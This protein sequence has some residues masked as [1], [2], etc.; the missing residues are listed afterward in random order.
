MNNISP[1]IEHTKQN[2]LVYYRQ[3]EIGGLEQCVF[4]FKDDVYQALTAWELSQKNFE[5]LIIDVTT[6]RTHID[7][8]RQANDEISAYSELSYQ[9]FAIN[10]LIAQNTTDP[11]LKAELQLTY[12]TENYKCLN[13]ENIRDMVDT[14][15][16]WILRINRSWEKYEEFIR[17]FLE[18]LKTSNSVDSLEY[19]VIAPFQFWRFEEDV[20]L[21]DSKD[22]DTMF[23]KSQMIKRNELLAQRDGQNTTTYNLI[24]KYEFHMWLLIHFWYFTFDI[25]KAVANEE[26]HPLFYIK[27]DRAKQMYQRQID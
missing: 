13:D 15:L 19:E 11:V 21:T 1:I 2:W 4:T 26:E 16:W 5:E 7:H 8:A 23:L 6:H 3:T 17:V 22:I 14:Y 20:F 9:L 25:N 27:R 12:A 18:S 10:K 24:K